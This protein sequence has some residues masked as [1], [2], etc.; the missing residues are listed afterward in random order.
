MNTTPTEGLNTIDTPFLAVDKSRFNANIARMRAYL[1]PFNVRLR[2]HLKTIKSVPAAALVMASK[3]DPATVSTLKE[4]EAFAEAGYTDLLYAVGISPQK[5]PRVLALQRKGVNI[6][7]LLDSR[8][9]AEMVVAFCREK[10]VNIPV[11]IEVDCDGHRAGLPADDPELVTIGRLMHEA[12]VEVRG[13]MSHSGGTYGCDTPEQLAAAAEQE[14]K[15]AVAAAQALRDAGVACPEVSVGSTPAALS[16][17]NLEGVT[18]VRAGVYTFF[19]LVMAGVGVCKLDDIALSVVTTVTGHNQAKGWIFVDA[20]WSALSRDR[21]TAGQKVDQ[22]YGVVCDEQG[23]VID[24]LLVSAVNQEH[25]ILSMREGSGKAL[26]DLP[27]GARLRILPN[28]ACATAGQF[29]QYHV[30]DDANHLLEIWPRI[31]GW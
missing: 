31:Q 19:D 4:A 11:Y 27:I 6:S 7:I 26:P 12:G 1:Q 10:E 28:H 14:R 24:D 21:G 5:A 20:G 18:E 15:A 2:P 25:G 22:L 8:Q 23:R 9:Q 3:Q 16:F 13:V 17:T 29:L 30:L